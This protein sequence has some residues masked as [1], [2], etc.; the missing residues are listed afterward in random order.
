MSFKRFLAVFCAIG[1]VAPFAQAK[2]RRPESRNQGFEWDDSRVKRGSPANPT[3]AYQPPQFGYSLPETREE[4]DKRSSKRDSRATQ[5][6]ESQMPQETW[7][8]EDGA[9]K[10]SGQP[11][12]ASA[13][14]PLP[15]PEPKTTLESG[16]Q[17][18]PDYS[19]ED[20][21]DKPK[22]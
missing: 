1:M 19:T 14:K 6:K 5:K 2:G 3:T 9:A 10:S 18:L 11:A 12:D 15:V 20:P 4:A 13:P 21:Y 16:E 7:T 8:F 17:A 22:K